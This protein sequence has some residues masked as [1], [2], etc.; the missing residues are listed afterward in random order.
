MVSR[1]RS[2]INARMSEPTFVGSL[3][4]IPFPPWFG[5]NFSPESD[6]KTRRVQGIRKGQ[7]TAMAAA[8]SLLYACGEPMFENAGSRNS[9]LEDRKA[10]A[11]EINNSP[12][13]TAYRQNPMAHPD[14]VRHVFEDMNRCI[15]GKGWKQVLSPQEQERLKRTMTS[16]LTH[17]R[18]PVP[19]TEPEQAGDSTF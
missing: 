1:S 7:A 17:A 10:C 8:M 5:M 4:P 16:E 3:I 14:F 13:A 2:I 12:A 18:T 11:V 19:I 6:R 15:E 9:L